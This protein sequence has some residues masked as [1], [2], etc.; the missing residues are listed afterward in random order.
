V[1]PQVR[2][3][4]ADT[5]SGIVD[6][7]T[8][9]AGRTDLVVD[10]VHPN[11]Q[12]TIEV[13]KLVVEQLLAGGDAGVAADAGDGASEGSSLGTGGAGETGGAGGTTGA[14]G[15]R[16]TG[17]GGGTSGGA[18]SSGSAALSPRSDSSGSGDSSGCSLAGAR[19]AR[20]SLLG[21][22]LSGAWLVARRRRRF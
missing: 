9:L 10:G 2:M 17:T 4:A 13:A 15:A 19:R 7:N 5:G 18:G 1:V 3:V 22:A 16:T 21:L 8:R 11:N 20:G 14:G 6:L 12:G